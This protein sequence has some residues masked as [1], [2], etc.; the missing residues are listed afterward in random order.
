MDPSLPPRGALGIALEGYSEDDNGD[1][2]VDPIG[3]VAP[4]VYTAP[5]VHAAPAVTYA[6][7]L[8]YTHHVAA[9]A[10]TYTH[11]VAA[12][13]TYTHTA[14]VGNLVHTYAGPHL[15]AGLPVVAAAP[16]AAEE[17]VK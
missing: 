2:F 16:A 14:H 4:A 3:Q 10:V 5:V 1:G 11:H 8:T 17:A 7:P 13:V 6:A 12:P 9:P 15:V